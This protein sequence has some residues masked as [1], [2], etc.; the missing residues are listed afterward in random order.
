MCSNDHNRTYYTEIQ[1]LKEFEEN[2]FLLCNTI[3][4][5]M[6]L[7]IMMV[8]ELSFDVST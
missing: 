5:N 3:P 4:L 8:V 6:T 7:L 1:I 2:I